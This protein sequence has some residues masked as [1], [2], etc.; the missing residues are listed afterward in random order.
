VALQHS[1]GALPTTRLLVLL[2]KP[3]RV[4]RLNNEKREKERERKV[5]STF[6]CFSW[7]NAKSFILKLF[8]FTSQF[9]FE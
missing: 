7:I 3:Y 1:E 8:P 9:S 5:V 2:G 4:E 6:L